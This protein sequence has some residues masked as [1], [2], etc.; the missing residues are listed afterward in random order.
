MVEIIPIVLFETSALLLRWVG[1]LAV[2][3]PVLLRGPATAALCA[4]FVKGKRHDDN[5]FE[6][7]RDRQRVLVDGRLGRLRPELQYEP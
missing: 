5:G 3:V 6:I 1:S 2:P 7:H 4:T